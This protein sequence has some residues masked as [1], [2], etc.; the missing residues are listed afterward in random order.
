MTGTPILA[1]L[2]GSARTAWQIVRG[3]V[4]ENAYERYLDHHRRNHSDEE[5]LTERAF[6]RRHVDRQDATP[7]SRCC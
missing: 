5:P 2:R 4:G 6:W 3:V 7:G 1:R